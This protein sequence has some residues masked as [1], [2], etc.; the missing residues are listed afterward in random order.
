MGD[1]LEVVESFVLVLVLHGIRN[2]VQH[3]APEALKSRTART[4]ELLQKFHNTHKLHRGIFTT[5]AFG[6]W[7]LFMKIPYALAMSMIATKPLAPPTS[8]TQDFRDHIRGATSAMSVFHKKALTIM[9]AWIRSATFLSPTEYQHKI[10]RKSFV[11]TRYSL[12]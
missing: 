8:T 2:L 5:A 1:V 12:V 11:D 4:E 9:K 10:A 3:I 6:S 7:H